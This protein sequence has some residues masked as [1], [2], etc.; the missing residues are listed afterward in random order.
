MG[1]QTQYAWPDGFAIGRG[2]TTHNSIAASNQIYRCCPWSSLLSLLFNLSACWSLVLASVR[3]TVLP[4][5]WRVAGR[6]FFEPAGRPG[7]GLEGFGA[8]AGTV[9]TALVDQGV[10]SSVVSHGAA[11]GIDVQVVERNPADKGFVPQPRRWV[12]EQTFGILS[13]HRRLVRDYEHRP[14]S[15]ASRVYWAMTDVMGRRLTRTPAP[16]WRAA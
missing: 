16:S 2:A 10:K 9:T 1:A 5:S 6:W 14:A 3:L 12:V 15:S 8:S 4:T 13:F 11:V 7:P